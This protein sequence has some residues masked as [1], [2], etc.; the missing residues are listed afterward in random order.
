MTC[1]CTWG[2]VTSRAAL[3]QTAGRSPLQGS[4]VLAAG[5]RPHSRM[6]PWSLQV[7]VTM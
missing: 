2:R 3:L 6:Q 1:T 5:R 4:A 7:S